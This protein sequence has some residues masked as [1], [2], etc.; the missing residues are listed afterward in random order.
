MSELN[1][2]P[3]K[4]IKIIVEGNQAHFITA[5]LDKIKASGYTVFNNL[6]G[7]GHHGYIKEHLLYNDTSSLQMILTV[8][9]KEKLEPI[10]AGIKPIIERYSVNLFVLDV[11]VLRPSHFNS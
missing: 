7:K 10:L 5:V 3:M 4:E 8:I 11:S 9:P 2:Y 6:S 1:L